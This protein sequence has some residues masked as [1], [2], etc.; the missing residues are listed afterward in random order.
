M[1]KFE[2]K[3]RLNFEVVLQLTEEEARALDALAG[4]EINSF[5]QAFYTNLGESYMKPHEKGLITLFE[6]ARNYLRPILSKMDETK[7]NLMK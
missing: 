6:D 7:K 1:A 5:L 3:P 4:Y 2:N